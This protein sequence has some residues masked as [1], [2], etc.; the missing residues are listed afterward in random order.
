MSEIN[1][2]TTSE[3][4]AHRIYKAYKGSN[5]VVIGRLDDTHVVV[6][7]K[8]SEGH[9][10]FKIISDKDID[11]YDENTIIKVKSRNTR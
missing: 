7:L 9:P 11:K 10:H 8:T 4:L 1:Q 5:P 6:K 3:E 2:D